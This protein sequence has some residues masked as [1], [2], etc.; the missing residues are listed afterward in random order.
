MLAPSL[1]GLA[2][3]QPSIWCVRNVGETIAEELKTLQGFRWGDNVVAR[4]PGDRRRH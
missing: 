3:F 2:R 1:K 4:R